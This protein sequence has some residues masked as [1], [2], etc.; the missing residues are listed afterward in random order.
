MKPDAAKTRFLER[1]EVAGLSLDALTPATG[2]E[3]MLA[4]YAEERAD[5]CS[6]DADG[7]MLL[8]QWGTHDWGDGP[9]FEVSIVR[10]LI[11]ADDEE[12]EPRQL[13]LR[14]RFGPSAGTIAGG[15]SRWC[16]S[17]DALAGFRPFVTGGS[18]ALAAVGQRHPESVVLRFGRT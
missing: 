14:F 11:M 1:L 10:Q 3:A 16:G 2:V 5:G 6:L 4:Y 18:Q 9:A 8:F 17:P 7:D 12:E 15:G 13:D